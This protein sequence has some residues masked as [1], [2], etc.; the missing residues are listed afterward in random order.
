MIVKTMTC[1]QRSVDMQ[2][3]H[4]GAR[5][6]KNKENH[7]LITA[8][9]QRA[10]CQQAQ[11]TVPSSACNPNSRSPSSAVE[12]RRKSTVSVDITLPEEWLKRNVTWQR[13]VWKKAVVKRYL[14]GTFEITV[15]Q[16]LTPE[17]ERYEFPPRSRLLKK[18]ATS[19]A[20]KRRMS[21]TI[22]EPN[23]SD[24]DELAMAEWF[25]K[26]VT[27]QHQQRQQQQLPKS[28]TIK[29]SRVSCRSLT[30][31]NSPKPSSLLHWWSTGSATTELHEIQL[32]SNIGK[33]WTASA[34][35]AS[36]TQRLPVPSPNHSAKKHYIPK[37]LLHPS[38]PKQNA[39][40]IRSTLPSADSSPVQAPH[41]PPV[42][43][44]TQT[45]PLKTCK[46]LP[47]KNIHLTSVLQLAETLHQT[48]EKQHQQ[49]RMRM[50]K[51]DNLLR[52]EQRS[53]HRSIAKMERILPQSRRT[54]VN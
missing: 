19:K 7:L 8:R 53:Q 20:E 11:R 41:P 52:E 23:V 38:S 48:L 35:A 21:A 9:S 40:T 29:R 4:A 14:D 39:W 5:H 2:A 3:T 31:N 10:K 24:H 22:T 43:A 46:R 45:W 26:G 34:A 16:N 12:Q 42:V 50:Q 32:Q 1:D 33:R 30:D 13:N 49:A 6:S 37:K 18:L 27:K 25:S 15:P 47:E 36:V 54:P 28:V 44:Q 51:L 17:E